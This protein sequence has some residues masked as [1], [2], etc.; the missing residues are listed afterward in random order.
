MVT[1]KVLSSV[2]PKKIT[3][4]VD[5]NGCANLSTCIEWTSEGVDTG[6]P[7]TL[8]HNIDYDNAFVGMFML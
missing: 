4:T 2:F 6:L 1:L 3:R 7:A 5:M 8:W